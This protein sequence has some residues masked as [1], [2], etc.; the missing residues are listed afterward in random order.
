[1]YEFIEDLP[2]QLSQESDRG[3]EVIKVM[4]EAAKRGSMLDPT[5]L[6]ELSL[7]ASVSD[8]LQRYHMEDA[9]RKNITFKKANDFTV[10]ADKNA[11]WH[12]FYN[13]L[14]NAHRHAGYDCQ[15]RLWLDDKN[16]RFHLKDDGE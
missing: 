16:R 12:M 5:K 11:L 1:M 7:K 6:E 9:Q 10:L 3:Y 15:L 2:Q 4:L 8:A 13:L 14:K